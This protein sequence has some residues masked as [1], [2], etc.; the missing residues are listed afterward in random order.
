MHRLSLPA[1]QGL[2]ARAQRCISISAFAVPISI[3]HFFD[4]SS[5]LS[6]S[7]PRN[8]IFQ[9]PIRE[10][11]LH[12]TNS[13]EVLEREYNPTVEEILSYGS[14]SIIGRLKPGIV[15]KSPR[16]SGWESPTVDAQD[17]I[18][19]GSTSLVDFF[20]VGWH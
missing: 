14:T 8:A 18:Q 10:R 13:D 16:F 19:E 3:F 6:L 11:E 9:V 20:A 17:V 15:L 5:L 7:G 4:L 1:R 2:A 12:I